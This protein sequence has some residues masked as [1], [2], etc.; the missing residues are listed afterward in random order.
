MVDAFESA[1][2]SQRAWHTVTAG[3]VRTTYQFKMNAGASSIVGRESLARSVTPKPNIKTNI[4]RFI[5]TGPIPSDS[6][7][8]DTTWKYVNKK[9]GPDRRF[10]NNHQ[11]PVMQYGH[12]DIDTPAGLN[13]LWSFSSVAAAQQFAQ[14]LVLMGS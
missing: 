12:V 6:R 8:V 10:N 11:I 4:A 1:Q 2:R 14:A 5:E 9:G 7:Q 13:L 3:A